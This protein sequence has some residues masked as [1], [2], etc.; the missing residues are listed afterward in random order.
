MELF[1]QGE[2]VRGTELVV[3]RDEA[4]V[5]ELLRAAHSL[6]LPEGVGAIFL[7]VEGND[8]AEHDTSEGHG[9]LL[10]GIGI[11]HR[12]CVHLHRKRRV[13]VTVHYGMHTATHPFAPVTTVGRVL[14]WAVEKFRLDPAQAAEHALQLCGSELVPDADAHI[15]EF[16]HAGNAGHGIPA[17]GQ[18]GG[19]EDRRGESHHVAAVCF[20]LIVKHRPQG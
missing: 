13:E 6:G 2:G 5:G 14:A 19:Q 15:G 7:F 16:V 18:Q 9:R 3:L 12:R 4:T 17:K 8:A 11:G 10:S 20:N 1:V